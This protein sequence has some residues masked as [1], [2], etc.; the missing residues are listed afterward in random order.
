[1]IDFVM[2]YIMPVFIVILMIFTIF[3]LGLF[4]KDNL[5]DN[6]NNCICEKVSDKKCG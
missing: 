3:I 5:F 2:D 6:T 1:M 4:I